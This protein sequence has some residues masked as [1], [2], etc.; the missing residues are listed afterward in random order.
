[1]AEKKKLDAR[2]VRSRATVLEAAEHLLFEEGW[3]ALTH[4][5]VAE[6][7]GIARATIYRHWPTVEDLLADVI[8]GHP[9][10]N[11]PGPRCGDTRVDLAYEL[12]ALVEHLQ[13]HKLDE[14]ILT[15]MERASA[16][17]PRMKEVHRAISRITRKPIWSVI[18]AGIKAG[19]LDAKL[20][21][22]TAAAH[23]IGP[24]L[25]LRLLAGRRITHGDI[26]AIIEA[27]FSAFA[28][29]TYTSA[30]SN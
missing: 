1:M 24:I 21:E 22:V 10:P 12:A 14:I 15:A 8:M 23:T 18:S 17:Q 29:K 27:F 28:T 9:A 30:V 25:Y 16:G 11:P 13:R 26:E 3:D 20:S 4:V 5:R 7:S 2:I 6:K 19:E